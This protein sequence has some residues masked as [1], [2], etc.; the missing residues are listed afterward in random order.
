MNKS[1]YNITICANAAWNIINFRKNFI[2]FLHK[3]N[4][5]LNI[6]TSINEQ[7]FDNLDFIPKKNLFNVAISRKFFS[8]FYDMV[9]IFQMFFYFYKNKT[10]L[11]ISYTVK[12]NLFCLLYSKIFR[13]KIILNITGL[14]TTF[15]TGSILKKVIFFF[16]KIFRHNNAFYIF[17]NQFD[18]NLFLENNLIIKNNSTVI[19]GSGVNVHYFSKSILKPINKKI[20][21]L[22]VGRV[23]KQKGFIELILAFLELKKK[24]TNIDLHVVGEIDNNNI[25]KI[26]QSYLDSLI[27]KRIINYFGFDHDV[28]SHME[29]ADCLVL[30]SYRE[31]TS[32]V[33]LE[34]CSMELPIITTDVPGCNNIIIDEFNGFLCKPKDYKDLLRV[35]NKFINTKDEEKYRMSKNS[36][37]F[38]INNFSDEVFFEKYI[39]YINNV[40]K[41]K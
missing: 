39:K 28:K 20:K 23:I 40:L 1:I 9:F 11:I 31:G 16:Y 27:N 24:H 17:Q 10:D 3:K 22:F 41:I 18:M 4:F 35:M 36:R 15:L 32:K 5:N 13:K 14:G 30:P 37:K 26:N 25:S 38:V 7:D 29:N 12:A 2:N 19:M 6:L 34:A 33:I 21:F 8:P